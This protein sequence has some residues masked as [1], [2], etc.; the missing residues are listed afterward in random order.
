VTT[1]TASLRLPARPEL[2][3]AARAFTTALLRGWGTP[4]TTVDDAGLLVT[5][6]AT[7]ALRTGP[8]PF[9]ITMTTHDGRLRVRVTTS[10]GGQPF[11]LVAGYGTWLVD[12]IALA[13]GV[14]DD[15]DEQT[16]W[17]EL[18]REDVD[19]AAALSEGSLKRDAT[20]VPV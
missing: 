13:W 6:L 18:P 1:S 10:R 7:A 14:D 15:E 5:E 20:V 19:A 12:A 17:F 16:C 4:D 11:L 9:T 8:A 2:I 3:P